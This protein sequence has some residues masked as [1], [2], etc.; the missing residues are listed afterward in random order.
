MQ[1]QLAFTIVILIWSTTPLA[2]NWSSQEVGFLFGVMTRMM[3]GAFF[4]SASVVM[5]RYRVRLDKASLLAYLASGIGIYVAMLF[6]YWGAAYIPSG[7]ISVI[8]GLSPII[9]G[10]MASVVLGEQALS[11][12]RV[13]GALL[14]VSGLA[15]IFLHS[16]NRSEHLA[17]GVFLLL[18]GVLGQTGSAVWIKHINAKVNGLVMSAAGLLI[19]VPL[20]TLTWWF[21]DGEWPQQIS[22]KVLGSI[23][24]LAFF[25]SVIGFTA[26]FFLL[27]HVEASRVSL[28]TLITPITALML[29]HYLNAETLG[30]PVILGTALVLAGLFSYEWAPRLRWA[31]R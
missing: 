11:R 18:I 1:I 27:N 31:S 16:A 12:H 30:A 24:Y 13:V 23:L 22:N 6:A 26:Y 20:F 17:F 4:A 15:V 25:G 21:M 5:L 10:V 7:W 28:I 29:G 14:G 19:S 8:W 3:L 9:T 2:I